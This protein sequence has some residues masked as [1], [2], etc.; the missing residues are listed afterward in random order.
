MKKKGLDPANIK[1]M[2]FG[3]NRLDHTGG[4][5]RPDLYH[6]RVIMGRDDWA[7]YFRTM[8][9]ANSPSASGMGARIKDKVAMTHDIDAEDGMKITLGGMTATIYTMTGHTPG[10]IGMIAPVK[11]AGTM[12]NIL[13]V[14]AA[15]DA[16]NRE[17]FIGGYGI[18][19][20][21]ASPTRW[22]PCTRFTP[23]PT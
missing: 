11:W 20:I 7:I 19:G 8:E 14:T 6:P 22:K 1:Y 4:G 23:T 15:T 13:I 12:H 16:K 17:A 9:N 21:S 3:H 2:V 5:H 18:S 10:S